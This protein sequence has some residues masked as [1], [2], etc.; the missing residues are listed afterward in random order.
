MTDG[1]YAVFIDI[2]RTLTAEDHIVPA[3]NLEA[4][5]AARAKGHLVF[6]NTGRSWGNI[7]PE[8]LSSLNVD[9]WAAGSG[10]H[11]YVDG[12]RIHKMTMKPEVVKKACAYFLGHPELWA[13]FEGDDEVL[14]ISDSIGTRRGRYREIQSPEDFSGVYADKGIE[15]LAAGPA[16]PRSFDEQFSG[17]LTVFRFSTYAD[18]VIF[19]NSKARAIERICAYTGIPR[20]RTIAIGDS[21]N[22]IPMLEYAALAGCMGN[23]QDTV[24]PYADFVGGDNASGGVADVIEH[25]LL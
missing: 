19:G 15:I 1:K 20:E 17:E 25:Y 3:R 7:P 14:L 9:G 23:S 5:A 22:D 8:L 4:I 16:L 12:V 18:C 11:I 10:A 6:I 21:A 24:F 13:I 2:D